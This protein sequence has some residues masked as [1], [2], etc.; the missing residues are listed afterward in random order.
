VADRNPPSGRLAILA[1]R[2]EE[3][4]QTNQRHGSILTLQQLSETKTL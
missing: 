1:R 3:L 4:H 2:P